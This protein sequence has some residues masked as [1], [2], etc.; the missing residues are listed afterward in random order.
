MHG[1]TIKICSPL[2]QGQL[3]CCVLL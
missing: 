1:T 3:C 2:F